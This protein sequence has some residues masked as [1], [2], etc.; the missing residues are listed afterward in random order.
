MVPNVQTSPIKEFSK[1]EISKG[2][3]VMKIPN[4]MVLAK[5]T[6]PMTISLSKNVI[7]DAHD[8]PVEIEKPHASPG[9]GEKTIK[10][11][12]KQLREA[13]DQIF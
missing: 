2:R 9:E 3:E 1:N 5:P 8:Q 6:T 4:K 13:K 7:L 10:W 12:N 11:L